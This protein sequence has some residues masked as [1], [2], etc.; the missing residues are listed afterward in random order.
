MSDNMW[1]QLPP[2]MTTWNTAVIGN[3]ARKLP[4]ITN[5]ISAV[6]WSRLD[7]AT[8]DADGLI[9][10]LGGTCAAPVTIR[11]N[12][13]AP[14]DI[15][16]TSANGDTKFYPLSPAFLQKIYADNVLG[17]PVSNLTDRDE[18]YIGPSQRVRNIK[19]VDAVKY[20]SKEA[21]EHIYNEMTKSAS[22]V[23]WMFTNMPEVMLAIHEK[24]TAP[25]EVEKT[26]APE[27]PD[28][29][30]AWKDHDTY[31]CNG[32]VITADVVNELFKFANAT[33]E[34]RINFMN[35]V[36]F[37]RDNREKIAKL[38]IPRQED[39]IASEVVDA[40][41]G[42]GSGRIYSDGEAMFTSIQLKS[43]RMEAGILFREGNDQIDER[44]ITN[45]MR[46]GYT[47]D[48]SSIISD[49]DADARYAKYLFVSNNGY[50]LAPAFVHTPTV[51][52]PVNYIFNNS[53]P[54]E[55]ALGMVGIVLSKYGMKAFGAITDIFDAG[56][57]KK[58][59]V[60]NYLTN[61][62]YTFSL[63]IDQTFF[64]VNGDRLDPAAAG[65][66][67]VPTVSFTGVNGTL[68]RDNEGNLVLEGTTYSKINCP[69]ALMSKYAAS[70][71]DAVEV[72]EQALK[73]GKCV[74]D[75]V[76]SDLSKTAARNDN[77]TDKTKVDNKKTR[78]GTDDQTQAEQAEDQA[79]VTNPSLASVSPEMAMSI[80][81]ANDTNMGF[82][83]PTAGRIR[84]VK[85]VTSTDLENVVQVNSPQV[86]DAYL[87][88][89]LANGSATSESLMKASDSIVDALSQLSQLLF[90]VRQEKYDFL[91]E[92]DI[93]AAM[94][95]LTD[96][97]S[98]I[99]VGN[100]PGEI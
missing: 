87:V 40:M 75:A 10:L 16:V 77:Q 11:A 94:N 50:A 20:A 73:T 42:E 60:M 65:E 68:A 18:D 82:G 13:M 7:P 67:N 99:G 64:E 51:Q 26:A 12:K 27:M 66:V 55:P 9:E 37:V 88:G 91:S 4:E 79:A 100:V 95:K 72:T 74:F 69:Y 47:S 59:T 86:M 39:Y 36:P 30:V 29:L 25:E 48:K 45:N 70:Y 57:Y 84:T 62:P 34:E 46:S 97:A 1:Y 19:T 52:V 90:L 83:I 14:I 21:V 49:R 58:V 17:K 89:N 81:L 54:S 41:A 78:Q 28:L 93:Q 33:E 98:A 31:K 43:G 76:E 85:P 53:E 96:V 38:V 56:K 92:N 22:V 61:L 35:G 44:D 2:D 32:E 24:A 15:L 6:T 63:G 3:I 71:E 8:G 80:D 23:D 5:Y